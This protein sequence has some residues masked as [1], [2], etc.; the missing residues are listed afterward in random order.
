MDVIGS[1]LTFC[2]NTCIVNITFQ[3]K[4]GCFKLLCVIG[5]ILLLTFLSLVID[6]YTIDT[7]TRAETFP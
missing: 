1:L 7:I 5:D 6:V 2:D 4:I 3:K